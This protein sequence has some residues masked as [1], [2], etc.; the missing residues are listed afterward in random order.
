MAA[1]AWD[2]PRRTAHGGIRDV[3]FSPNVL[4]RIAGLLYLLVAALSLFSESY[5]RAGV[6][7]AGDAAATADNIRASA[8]LFRLGIA[9]DLAHVACLVLAAFAL[10]ALLAP[11]GAKWAG[12]FVVLIAIA[13]AIQAVN[14]FN[15]AGALLAATDS[16]FAMAM[17]ADSA[18]ALALFFLDLHTRGFEIARVFAALWLLPL[19]Y[20]VYASG[21][22]PRVL[23][24]GLM[25]GC[26]GYLAQL[27]AIYASSDFDPERGLA[28]A[29]AAGLAESALLL[30]LLVKGV[31]EPRLNAA[32][33]AELSPPDR[34]AAGVSR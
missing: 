32:A 22:L 11:V 34:P 17:G 28:F 9:A 24:I 13:A 25:L 20:L 6:K 8:M 4:A 19:G 30:W 14:L 5:V 1:T 10:Y 15:H 2:A 33:G 23:G 18:D 16:A 21:F 27:V 12:A 7:A 3:T 29:V 26:F 31:R